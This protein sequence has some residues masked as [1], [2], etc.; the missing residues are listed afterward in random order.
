MRYYWAVARDITETKCLREQSS[1]AARLEAAGTVAGQVAHDFN[2]L[3][4]PIVAYPEMIRAELPAG[5]KCIDYL[6]DM[7]SS[8][9]KISDINQD[10]LTLGRRGYYN[11]EILNLNDILENALRQLR[12]RSDKVVFS[13]SKDKDLMSIKG[14]HAQIY[15][16]LYNLLCNSFDAMREIGQI[17]IKTENYY[18]D[19][20]TVAFQPIPTGEYVKLTLS[21]TGQGI[22]E[23][24]KNRIFDPFF[25]T[26]T[27]G[28]QRGSGLGLSIVDAVLRDHNAYLDLKSEIGKG[29]TFYIYFPVCRKAP[30][31]ITDKTMEGNEKLMVVD[32][33]AIQRELFKRVLE[34]LGY[35]VTLVESG[36]E[37]LNYLKR[38]P[39]DLLILDMI[40]PQGIDGTETY[41]R[42]LEINPSQKAI[43]VSGFS[44][45][46]RVRAAQKL[47]AGIFLRKPLTKKSIATAVRKELGRNQR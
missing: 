35:K 45:T 3:L 7:E 9:K 5:H 4:G 25:T 34:P 14:G 46:S 47:G 18:C 15:R 17:T 1:R 2:N 44:E 22:P 41:K 13:V 31:K 42:T 20:S 12:L 32:D 11:Q 33:D 43:I 21:D 37:A 26:K 19:D 27:L 23:E 40:M 38:D 39:H 16:M 24:I 36:E 30:E 6:N 29:T 8:A 10:L 28:K